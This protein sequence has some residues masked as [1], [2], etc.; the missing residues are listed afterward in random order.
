MLHRDGSHL[1]TSD[2]ERP[3]EGTEDKMRLS[4]VLSELDNLD[5]ADVSL[6]CS[7]WQDK[8]DHPLVRASSAMDHCSCRSCSSVTASQSSS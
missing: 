8:P 6:T 7:E 5:L 4:L 2:P 1:V 3:G